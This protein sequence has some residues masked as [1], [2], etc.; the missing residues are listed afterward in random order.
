MTSDTMP[1]ERKDPRVART[2]KLLWEAL[3]ALMGER[4]YTRITVL[5]IAGRAGVN[6]ATFYRHFEDIDDLFIQG[7]R[8]KLEPIARQSNLESSR[9][10]LRDAADFYAHITYLFSLI[11][12]ERDIFRVLA[13]SGNSGK[14]LSL[15]IDLIYETL[16]K[17]RLDDLLPILRQKNE[18]IPDERWAQ[19]IASMFLGLVVW[20]VSDD[21]A[22][23]AGEIAQVYGRVMTHGIIGT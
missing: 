1:D 21:S 22:I 4:V 18:A 6:R 19:V 2:R 17:N 16:L 12:T 23:P 3:V 14:I 20:W 9:K 5:D 11:E 7:F 13:A 15:A 8:D 10:N